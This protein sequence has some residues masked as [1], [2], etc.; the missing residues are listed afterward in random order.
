M[1]NN[2]VIDQAVILAGGFGTR[3]GSLTKKIPKPLIKIDNKPFIEYLLFNLSRQGFRKVLILCSYKSHFFFKKYHNKQYLNLKIICLK[4]N[5]PAG[6]GGALLNAKNFL[7][8]TFLLCNGD[9]YLDFNINNLC[10]A[11][12]PK[13]MLALICSSYSKTTN[14]YTNI[15][16]EKNGLVKTFGKINKSRKF[17]FNAGYYVCSKKILKFLNKNCSLE[18][19]IF[20]KI[21][22]NKKLYSINNNISYKKFIDIGILPDLKKAKIFL[23]KIINKPAIF[24]DR[25]GVLNK[26]SGYVY[27][28][29]DFIWKKNIIKLIKYFNDNNYY[30]VV[31]TNQSG[32]GR[33]FYK[34][35]EVKKLHDWINLE[36]RKKGAFIDKFYYAP[37]YSN[38][39]YAIYR[40]NKILRKPNVGMLDLALKE[41]NINLNKSIMLGDKDIDYLTAKKKKIKFFF[42]DFNKKIKILGKYF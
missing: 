5:N 11:F 1:S 26:D 21:I 8:N 27:K 24:L 28:I 34:E 9:T 7:K 10:L 20:P 40:K 3:L 6:T 41:F 37:Y 25:D 14:R 31:L 2:K 4:E 23:K 33:G 39:K 15:K 38:S 32:V 17:Y 18:N 16:I 19:D 13:K 30:V 35:K 12:N 29:K 42:V 36:L 22:K